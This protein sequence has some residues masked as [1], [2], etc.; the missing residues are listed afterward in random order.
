MR[1]VRYD[2]NYGEPGLVIEVYLPKKAEFQGP[3]Y[4]TLSRGFSRSHVKKH[5]RDNEDSIRRLLRQNFQLRDFSRA[6][7]DQCYKV[8]SGYSVYEVDGAFGNKIQER[9]QVVRIAFVPDFEALIRGVSVR[10]QDARSFAQRFFRFWTQ[11]MEGFL[12]DLRRQPGHLR[13]KWEEPLAAR[14]DDW[15]KH[16]GMF[17]TG[18]IVHEICAGID[19]LVEQGRIKAGEDEIWVTSFRSFALNR[20]TRRRS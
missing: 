10:I 9:T 12:E 15:M 6:D 3:L 20:I 7:S 8:F 13:T 17:V 18:Y 1:S 19:D 2:F 14:L 4:E 5:F 11:D 16:V